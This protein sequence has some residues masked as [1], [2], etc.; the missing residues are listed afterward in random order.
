MERIINFTEEEL[1]ELRD[2]LTTELTTSVNI[3]ID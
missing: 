1:T 3:G 2:E